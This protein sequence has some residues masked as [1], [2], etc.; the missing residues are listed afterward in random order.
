MNVMYISDWAFFV[1]IADPLVG[2]TYMTLMDISYI[3]SLIFKT[4]SMWLVDVITWKSCGYAEFSNSTVLLT[5]NNCADKLAVSE[6]EKFGGHCQIDID[7]YYIEVALNVVFGIF[8]FQ[9][10]K[11]IINYLQALPISDWHVLSNQTKHENVEVEL[12]EIK[13]EVQP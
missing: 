6:C 13:H 3:G 2:G 1:R 7:G 9:W 11:K 10:A 12:L 8:W 5:D 4:F